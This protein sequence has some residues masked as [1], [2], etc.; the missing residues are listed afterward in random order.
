[1]RDLKLPAGSPRR[2]NIGRYNS[3]AYAVRRSKE[4]GDGRGVGM[5]TEESCGQNTKPPQ[6]SCW[7]DTEIRLADPIIE[8]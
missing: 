2:G 3:K 7:E 6:Q 5:A 4:G 8:K 1:M